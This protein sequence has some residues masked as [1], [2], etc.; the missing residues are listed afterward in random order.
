MTKAVDD[1]RRKQPDG[2]I[3]VLR[4]GLVAT[5]EL[6]RGVGLIV[7][8]AVVAGGGRVIVPVLV[9]QALDHV[10]G[11]SGG[12]RRSVLPLLAVGVAVLAVTT[13]AARATQR[14]LV[15]NA[16]RALC[17]LRIRAFRHVHRMAVADLAEEQRGQ[18]VSRVTSDIET[19]SQFLQWGGIMWV[20]NGT[21]MIVVLGVMAVY[22]WRLASVALVAVAPLAV[23]L[24]LVQRRLVAA[25]DVLRS[26]VGDLLGAA[27]EA[28]MAAAVIR[29]YG[30][31]ADSMG[32]LERTI[33][34][35]RRADIQASVIGGAL[36]PCS[37]LFSVLSVSAVIVAGVLLGPAHGMSQGK[38]VAF[39]F[40]VGLF[41]EPVSEFT[42]I[43]DHTQLAVA[44]WRKVLD[45]LDTPITVV[46]PDPA[47]AVAL[48]DAPPAIEI[49]HVSYAYPTG[50]E[51]L[52]DITTSVRPGTRV[53]LVGATGSGKSTLARLLGRFCDPTEGTVR[54]GGVDLRV[55]SP[56]SLRRTV[57][58]VPQEVFLFDETVAAN[59]RFARA[60]ATDEEVLAAFADLGLADWVGGLPL[61][62]DT[63]VGERGE[64]LSAGERQLVALARARLA[65]PQ[66]LVLDEATSAV[67]PATAVRVGRA[68]ERLAN[69][70][71]SV[72][73]AHRLS[74][75]ARADLVLVLDGGRLVEEG[76]HDVL[77]AAGGTYARLYERWLEVASTTG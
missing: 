8:F 44:G 6:R 45:L 32:R 56:T 7:V 71:T 41:L 49:D 47:V 15:V 69:G 9:Q 2:A 24:R 30:A 1:R 5:P 76:S 54:V 48:P 61:G 60:E 40:L 16:E 34:A 72:T 57:V 25:Y 38:L 21:L 18:L 29:G 4:R 73:V 33:T 58:V 11:R 50:G 37:D 46:N 65:D 22:D 36:F 28:I 12:H 67:D 53:A 19:I 62:L 43:I 51:V 75:A 63:P 70:R 66:C 42:E 27:S 52:H 39:A 10:I 31:E 14:R 55:A 68:L 35:R 74:T 64:Q 13:L 59:V 17:L 26:R 77:V 3:A 23:V 20:I